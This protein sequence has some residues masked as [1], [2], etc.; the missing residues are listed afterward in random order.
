MGWVHF[1]SVCSLWPLP[2]HSVDLG[3]PSQPALEAPRPWV[4]A[5][6]LAGPSHL[7]HRRCPGLQSG[8]VMGGTAILSAV[9]GLTPHMAGA[10]DIMVVQQPDGTLKCSPFYGAWGGPAVV[11]MVGLVCNSRSS[12]RLRRRQSTTAA[13]MCCLRQSPAHGGVW[14]A[15][16]ASGACC[17]GPV[18]LLTACTYRVSPLCSALWQVHTHAQQRQEGADIRQR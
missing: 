4:A 2:H 17:W 11:V 18:L 5:A 15:M 6:S 8:V 14:S 1:L 7:V 10:I 16:H 9:N 13:C 12:S 3:V